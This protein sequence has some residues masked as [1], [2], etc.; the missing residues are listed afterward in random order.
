MSQALQQHS[1]S[2]DERGTTFTRDRTGTVLLALA[3]VVLAVWVG[4]LVGGGDANAAP[5][6]IVLPYGFDFLLRPWLWALEG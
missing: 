6:E 2:D 3:V 5:P 1:Y 4:V